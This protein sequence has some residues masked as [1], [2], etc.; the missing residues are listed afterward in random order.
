[1]VT[2]S[3]HRPS[4]VPSGEVRGAGGA[5][6][7]PWTSLN[8]ARAR[9]PPNARPTAR[10]RRPT[11]RLSALPTPRTRGRCSAAQGDGEPRG[12]RRGEP[13]DS[14]AAARTHQGGAPRPLA[15]PTRCA[16]QGLAAAACWAPCRAG[17]ARGR[18]APLLPALP[19]LLI[20]P[21]AALRDAS[22]PRGAAIEHPGRRGRGGAAAAWRRWRR[23]VGARPGHLRLL[24]G[25]RPRR[26]LLPAPDL[27]HRRGS[28]DGA[29]ADVPGVRSRPLAGA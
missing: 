2:R 15:V 13:D 6:W 1:M 22:Q 5:V 11:P 19:P 24:D 8:T 9:A 21:Y 18:P 10:R 26:A 14:C 12:E 7:V 23:G 16:R 4:P 20:L 27:A 25:R 28:G 3:P 29:A 17:R